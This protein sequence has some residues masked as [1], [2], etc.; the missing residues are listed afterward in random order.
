MQLHYHHLQLLVVIGCLEKLNQVVLELAF[1]S[2]LTF[3][4]VFHFPDL[5]LQAFLPESQVFHDQKEVFVYAGKVLVL[6][7]HLIDLVFELADLDVARPNF[8]LELLDLIIK[9]E[10][11]LFKFLDLLAQVL[12]ASSLLVQGHFSLIDLGLVALLHNL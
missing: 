8:L 10:L 11:K 7:F 1:S 12:N 9:H 5:I 6:S 4:F 3:K 2:I